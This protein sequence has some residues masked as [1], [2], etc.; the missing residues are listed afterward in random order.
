MFLS[1]LIN[2]V[3]AVKVTGDVL[4]KPVTGIF[5]NSREVVKD[6]VF[7]AIRGLQTDGHKYITDAL[8]KG[9][10]A[11]V[12]EDK[13]SIPDEMFRRSGQAKII[14]SDSRFALAQLSDAYYG[15]PSRRLKLIGVTGTKGKTTSTFM[16]KSVLEQAGIKT[17]L[18]GTIQNMIGSEVVPTEFTTPEANELNRLISR[19][20]DAGCEACVM[21][22]SSHSLFMKRVALLDFDIAVF[23]NLAP[24][25][26]DFHKTMD[27][28]AAAK[29]ILFDSLKADARAIVNCDDA[30][31]M[32]M[33]KDCKAGVVTYGTGE[34]ADY[35]IKDIDI[36]FT[37]TEFT[38]N[39]AD[40]SVKISTAL[41]GE[42]NAFNSTVAYL[43]GVNSGLESSMVRGAIKNADQV[44]GRFEILTN[45][46]KK[47]IIDY[48]HNPSSLEQVLKSIRRISPDENLVTVFGCGGNRDTFKRPVMGRIA[49]ELSNH[50]IV[51]SD[52]PRYEDPMAIISDIL[53]GISTGNYEI[54]PERAAAIKKAILESPDGSVILLAGKGHED[55]LIINGVKS[56]LSDRE[57]AAEY[58]GVTENAENQ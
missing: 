11:V 28:Y 14:V 30:Y 33:V 6:S 54:E 25:H 10:I 44:P 56:H 58:L 49:A 55:Y 21:E 23:T 52:N 47:V 36:S 12:V 57:L 38:L 34:N 53:K 1:E 8:S 50:V 32:F 5:H 48:A 15:N 7:V 24:E 29:K 45:G 31:G 17:G 46:K 35:R 22:V 9:A 27:E 26:L 20:A 18:I 37:G 42:F 2:H 40:D 39:T 3:Y 13:D 16:I 41:K 4:T 51:T 19:M 43:S